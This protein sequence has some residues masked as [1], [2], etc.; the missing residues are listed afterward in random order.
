MT[1]LLENRSG[2]DKHLGCDNWSKKR[3][4]YLLMKHMA[5]DLSTQLKKNSGFSSWLI[6]CN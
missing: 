5:Q 4:V 6:F 1:R 2:P 3:H